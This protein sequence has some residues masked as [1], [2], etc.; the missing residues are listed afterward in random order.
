[1]PRHRTIP[2]NAHPLSSAYARTPAPFDPGP[3]PTA[4]DL[5]AYADSIAETAWPAIVEERRTGH[6]DLELYTYRDRSWVLCS[7]GDEPTR[8]DFVA[9]V[10]VDG[11]YG[12]HCPACIDSMLALRNALLQDLRA[13]AADTGMLG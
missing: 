4:A 7:D 3:A 5:C 10:G 13:Y 1:M 6:T 12:P 9:T 11:E 8:Q 2:T